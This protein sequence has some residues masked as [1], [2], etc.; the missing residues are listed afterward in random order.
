[1]ITR[2]ILVRHATCAR[3]DS[4]LFGRAVDSPLDPHGELQARELADR[5]AGCADLLVEASPRRR[6]QQTAAAIAAVT[7]CEVRTAA[8]LDEVDF[9]RWAGASFATLA[10][11]PDWRRWNEQRSRACTP[12]G[13]SM[14]A[15]Q[16]RAIG[17]LRRLHEE[18]PGRTIAAV[19]HAEVLRAALMYCLDAPLDDYMRY[20]ID[21]ASCTT[22][23][24]SNGDIVVHGINE[25][26]P[27]VRAEPVE[28][29]FSLS[30][31]DCSTESH[32]VR[33]RGALASTP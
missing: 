7:G 26:F 15:V 10:Q 18:H 1:V 11:D 21:P 9:G 6:T 23:S 19:T 29:I 2:F 28:A 16:V 33:E 30:T 20:A 25:P 5:F 22:I 27:S 3:M 14:A 13:D 32:G 12:S 8:A 24:M 4:V 31:K 17:H